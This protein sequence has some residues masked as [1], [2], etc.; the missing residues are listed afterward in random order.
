MIFLNLF[1]V[2]VN[3]LAM[4]WAFGEG[5]PGLGLFNLFAVLLNLFPVVVSCCDGKEVVSR[6]SYVHIPYALCCRGS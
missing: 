2:V 1:F 4:A 6:G 3:S 5:K